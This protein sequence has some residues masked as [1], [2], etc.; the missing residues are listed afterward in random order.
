V[1]LIETELLLIALVK[2]EL[3]RRKQEGSYKGKASFVNHFFGYEGRSGFP[4]NFDTN[5]CNSLGFAAALLLASGFT[6]YMAAVMNLTSQAENWKVAGV[7]LTSLMHLEKRGDKM[8]PV[9]QKALVDLKGKAFL[10]FQSVRESWAAE[11]AFRF[12]GPIQFFG[13]PLLTD[14]LP[15]SLTI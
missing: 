3:E 6:G 2:K 5:Y 14:A 12:P 4:S 15:L 11:D 7:P 9:I 13:D 1:S 8:K 10:H